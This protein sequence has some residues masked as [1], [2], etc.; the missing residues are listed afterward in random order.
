MEEYTA[1]TIDP[2]TAVT[3]RPALDS[4]GNTIIRTY[5]G[6]SLLWEQTIIRKEDHYAIVSNL[7]VTESPSYEE[8]LAVVAKNSK[9]Y[10][11]LMKDFY[12]PLN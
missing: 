7:G 8:A 12:V 2:D 4:V 3:Y 9:T 10:F 11:E 5:I 6:R 1:V